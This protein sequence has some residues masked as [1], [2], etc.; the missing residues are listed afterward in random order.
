[1]SDEPEAALADARARHLAGDLD[2]AERGYRAILE[3]QPNHGEALHLL[4]LLCQQRGRHEQGA[5]L[6]GQAVAASPATALYHCNLGV[7][8][9][10]LGEIDRSEA[11]FRQALELDPQLAQGHY[12]LGGNCLARHDHPAAEEEFRLAIEGAPQLKEAHYNL[13]IALQ[14]Q[15]RRSE[16]MAAYGQ[17][18]AI[19]PSYAK[20]LLNL[21]NQ[22]HRLQRWDEALSV[23]QRL[24]SVDPTSA[25]AQHMTA[26]LSGVTTP[27]CPPAYLRALFDDCAATYDERLVVDLGYAAPRQLRELICGASDSV[28]AFRRAVDLGCGTGLMG[29]EI[30]PF[31]QHLVGVDLSPGMVAEAERTGCYDAL[32]VIDLVTHLHGGTEAYDLVVAAD[33]FSYWGDLTDGFEA[34]ASRCTGG[35]RFAF[36]T[37]AGTDEDVVLT[38]S[39]RYRHHRRAIAKLATRTGFTLVKDRAGAFRRERDEPVAGQLFLYEWGG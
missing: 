21:G 6:L 19:D 18:L 10:S 14:R 28:P 11:C 16:A 15:D 22:L 26:A 36:T 34:V 38:R 13:G 4:G 3:E 20:A 24:A 35:A 5:E 30:R 2:Q 25:E 33:V 23:Y 29:R 27:G 32:E 7:A 1:M 39:G 17:A 8:W 31:C 12:H 37:E 9:R